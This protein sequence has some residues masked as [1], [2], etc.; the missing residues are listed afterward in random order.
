MSIE[1]SF[2]PSLRFRLHRKNGIVEV[3]ET[4]TMGTQTAET[5]IK[6]NKI[7]EDE[8]KKDEGEKEKENKEKPEKEPV[9][10][11]MPSNMSS[12]RKKKGKNES[13]F[14]NVL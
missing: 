4:R 13:A 1:C 8:K 12:A 2:F 6:V 14:C 10:R 11:K 5:R 7:K 9:G 3:K